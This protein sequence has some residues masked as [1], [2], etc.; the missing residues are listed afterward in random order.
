[1]LDE[2]RSKKPVVKPGQRRHKHHQW[3]TGDVGHPELKDHLIG[4]IALMRA[5]VNWDGFKRNLQRAF[6]KLH[7]TK[8]MNLDEE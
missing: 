5:S 7:E 1:M 8:P 3:L 2:L 6:P 4:A